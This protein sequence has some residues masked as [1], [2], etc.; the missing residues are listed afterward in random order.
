MRCLVEKGDR[1][2]LLHPA[3]DAHTLGLSSIA[4]LV[5]LCGIRTVVADR[6]VCAS[7]DEDDEALGTRTLKDWIRGTGI[8]VLG[9]SYRLDPED[10]ER[11]FRRFADRLRRSRLFAS[12]GGP[13]KGLF[14]AGLPAACDLVL[15]HHPFVSGVFRGDETLLESLVILGIPGRDLPSSLA[16]GVGYDESRMGFGRELIRKADYRSVARVARSYPRFGERGDTVI[17][18]VSH[19]IG[20][21]LPPLMR[22]HVGPY[23][24][25]RIEAVEMFLDWTRQLA[26]SGLLDILSIGTSQLSQAAFGTDWQDR[27]NGGGVPINAPGELAAV[28]NAA[29]PML[30]RSYAGTQ[31][32]E[33]MARIHEETIDIAWHA[34]SLWWFCQIDGRGPNTV[35][36]NL[37]EHLA[38]LRD[39]AA[40]GKPF[41]PNVPHHFAF[42]GSDDLS[43]VV[44]GYL[45]ARAAKEAGIR[46]LV[47]QVMLN[48]P[49][50]TWGVQDLAKARTLLQLV[51]SLEDPTF[52]VYLQP[53][54]GLDYF[55]R[56]EDKAKAQLAAVTALMDDIEPENPSSPQIIH[57]VGYSEATQ[58]ADPAVVDESIR[59]TRHALSEYRHRKRKGEMPDMVRN[60][61]VMDRTEFLSSE[62]RILI[63]AIE[64][65]ID[66][67][68]S[69][70][71]LYEVMAS[72]YFPLPYLWECREEF[73]EAVA[74]RTQL[75]EGGVRTVDAEGKPICASDRAA[76]IATRRSHG[77]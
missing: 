54:G 15:V 18:R 46:A 12:E 68:Y 7:I 50:Y 74:W 14:Y 20:A 61:E 71:G 40:S 21:G 28:W 63:H 30:V 42:R 10:G 13:I 49:K 22:A 57:V 58:L 9:F 25:D 65:S 41:E 29:R 37:R 48:T 8:T 11:L 23:L 70:E 16:A 55:A 3:I 27:P 17:A 69:A 51:R 4:Q 35:Q 43:Y 31:N 2:G 52:R 39:I 34:L 1:L 45:A 75:Y 5:N 64:S 77:R 47:L 62:A 33:P 66:Q 60:L 73:A 59:I 56:D 32:I 44:S 38:A 72:G 36:E 26:R 24:P 67:P 76:V 19:G 53:R 6:S